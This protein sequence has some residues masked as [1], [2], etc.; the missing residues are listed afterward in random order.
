MNGVSALARDT[1]ETLA[2]CATVGRCERVLHFMGH[3]VKGR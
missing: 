1:F 2:L 3:E